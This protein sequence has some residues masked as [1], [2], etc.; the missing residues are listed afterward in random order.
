MDSGGRGSICLCRAAVHDRRHQEH[1]KPAESC[2]ASAR[3]HS[4]GHNSGPVTSSKRS[5]R[6]Q[7][8]CLLRAHQNRQQQFI[9]THKSSS[10][11]ARH[12][13][14]CV[15]GRVILCGLTLWAAW[16]LGNITGS[17]CATRRYRHTR[18]KS[19]KESSRLASPG[20]TEGA[21]CRR[22]ERHGPPQPE[23]MVQAALSLR[24]LEAEALPFV[25]ISP[26]PP[27]TRAGRRGAS[28]A[29]RGSA[30]KCAQSSAPCS[31]CC[32]CSPARWLPSTSPATPPKLGVK[33]SPSRRLHQQRGR[34]SMTCC[35][36]A[37]QAL[38]SRP[39]RQR[40][41]SAGCLSPQS[42]RCRR[43]SPHARPAR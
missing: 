7:R 12:L 35:S 38:A 28:S 37:G 40:P 10:G 8:A 5:Q 21:Q 24:L 41:A 9:N 27:S 29:G 34:V 1:A 13:Q 39:A 11:G 20:Q 6:A 17:C 33:L 30:A 2:P 42:C 23:A 3:S 4:Q 36:R 19:V 25:A 31:S 32:H 26:A 16:W 43:G 14:V 15:A 18:L 22:S